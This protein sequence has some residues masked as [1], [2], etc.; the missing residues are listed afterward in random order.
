MELNQYIHE[1]KVDLSV[2]MIIIG[3]L[4]VVISMG[5]IMADDGE[6]GAFSTIK[7]ST[8]GWIYWLM[9]FG[10]IIL[11]FGSFYFIDF[12]IKR[13]EFYKLFKERSKS[14]FIKNQDRIEE[15]AWR[16]HPKYEEMVIDKKKQLKIR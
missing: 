13:K 10:T 5:A 7:D 15:L 3:A 16:L 6:S 12:T 14:K 2:T 11:L 9:I 8:G 4:L 1:H